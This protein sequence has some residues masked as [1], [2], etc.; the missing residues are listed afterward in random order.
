[1]HRPSV[2]VTRAIPDAGLDVLRPHG[3]VAVNLHDRPPSRGE[4]LAA[5]R[6]CDGL[7]A[8]LADRVDA[9]LF[10][11]APRLRVVAN[12]AVGLDNVDIPAASE[13][14]PVV[15]EAALAHALQS[16]A[17]AGAGLDV[18]E[19]EPEIHPGLLACPTAVL[20]PHVGS[21]TH[22]TRQ[23]MAVMTCEN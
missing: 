11:A 18:Y 15:D 14:G 5:V 8:M 13:R 7:V 1:M 4:L 9:A 2:Y 17:I 20:L 23:R 19:K 10:D 21:G 22:D 16:G 12:F 3:D 6:G